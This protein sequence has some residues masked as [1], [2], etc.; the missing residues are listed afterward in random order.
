MA[1]DRVAGLPGLLAAG[2]Q[3]VQH[4]A[5]DAAAA[6][7]ARAVG[8]LDRILGAFRGAA[9]VPNQ[10]EGVDLEGADDARIEALEVEQQHLIVQSGARPQ[11]V[12]ALG[13]LLRGVRVQLRAHRRRHHPALPQARQVEEVE[14]GD[15]GS[16]P[17]RRHPGERAALHGEGHQLQLLQDVE[18][19]ARVGQIVLHEARRIIGKGAHDPVRMARTA[20]AQGLAL[21]ENLLRRG[22][23]AVTLQPHRHRAQQANAIQ[24]DPPG[25]EDGIGESAPAAPLALAQRAGRAA[26]LQRRAGRRRAADQHRHVEVDDVPAGHHVGIQGA[27]APPQGGQ[28][29]RFAGAR[30]GRRGTGR[31]RPL[32]GAPQQHF[33]R[34]A[35]PQRHRQQ[36]LVGAGLDVQRQRGERRRPLRRAQRRL[37]EQHG[38]GGRALPPRQGA[39]LAFDQQRAADAAV[40]QIAVGEAH[41][42]LE[43]AQPGAVQ[44]RAQRRGL[45]RTRQPHPQHRLALQRAAVDRF[46]LRGA[47]A[48]RLLAGAALDVEIGLRAAVADHEGAAV[49][50]LPVEPHDRAAAAGLGGVGNVEDEPELPAHGAPGNSATGTSRPPC[51]AER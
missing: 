37:V 25:N 17:V 47:Q 43:G 3:V 1:G 9:A 22:L 45:G 15:G 21:A 8:G 2:E 34:P 20:A 31:A 4:G 30:R 29:L 23:Q 26:P 33:P 35:A 38:G 10:P 13:M 6:P 46:Q 42:G 50:Q 28:Q 32:V 16:H 49:A 39:R 11:D 48:Q 12:A 24:H 18:R 36:P 14:R 27:D 44:A 5:E 51:A 19:Q 7:E 40:D 41:V